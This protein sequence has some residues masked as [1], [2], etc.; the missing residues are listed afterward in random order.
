MKQFAP[1]THSVRNGAL[2]RRQVVLSRAPEEVL[3]RV[4]AFFAQDVSSGGT[5]ERNAGTT[6]CNG[7]P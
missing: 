3:E 7:A 1:F 4:E 5:N 6:I 2:L